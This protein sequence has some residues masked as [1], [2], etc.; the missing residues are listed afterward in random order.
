M[1]KASDTEAFV[2]PSNPREI[3]LVRLW[4]IC[5]WRTHFQKMFTQI[6]SDITP[7]VF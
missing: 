1:E 3:I 5:D 4:Y 2:T 7:R 6:I